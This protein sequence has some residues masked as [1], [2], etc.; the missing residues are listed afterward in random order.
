MRV[1]LQEMV[2]VDGNHNLVVLPMPDKACV[3]DTPTSDGRQS[4]Y[5]AARIAGKAC[6]C[7]RP[8]HSEFQPTPFGTFAAQ[9]PGQMFALCIREEVLVVI[10]SSLYVLTTRLFKIQVAITFF[11]FLH[12]KSLQESSSANFLSWTF[13]EAC[14]KST[15]GGPTSLP[16]Q[17]GTATT[18]L[19]L[20]ANVYR[21][22]IHRR[23][24]CAQGL[25]ATA[26]RFRRSRRRETGGGYHLA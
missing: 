13:L 16:Q 14:F 12:T 15:L 18:T 9:Q 8:T 17:P 22:G 4:G 23:I 11:H 1:E 7:D 20:T 24:S 10:P 26:R 21:S 19:H 25:E 5:L 3:K 6:V 2:D